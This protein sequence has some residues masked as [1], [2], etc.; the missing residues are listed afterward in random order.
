MY[1]RK[2]GDAEDTLGRKCLCN[3]LMANVGL[4]QLRRNGYKEEPAV[5]LGQ[6][7]AGAVALIEM[8]PDGWTAAKALDWLLPA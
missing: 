8:H 6:D 4:G 2:G 5:T 7:L 3:A 1:L